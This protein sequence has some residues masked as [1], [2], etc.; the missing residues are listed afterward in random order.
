[1][2]VE[3]YGEDM[4]SG[5]AQNKAGPTEYPFLHVTTYVRSGVTGKAFNAVVE[6]LSVLLDQL[7]VPK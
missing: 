3:S 5:T 7:K 2:S 1:M 4:K 6:N